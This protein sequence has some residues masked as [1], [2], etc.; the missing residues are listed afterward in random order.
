MVDSKALTIRFGVWMAGR[1]S[2]NQN[3]VDRAC[4]A[5]LEK[6]THVEPEDDFMRDDF[7][8]KDMGYDPDELDRYQRG[9]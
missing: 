4:R 6:M 9:E 1:S 7:V 2:R 8:D 5:M 3:L